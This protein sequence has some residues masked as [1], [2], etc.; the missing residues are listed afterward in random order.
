MADS[1][2]NIGK[3]SFKTNIYPKNPFINKFTGISSH[4]FI[5]M[6]FDNAQTQ[7]QLSF[8]YNY[9]GLMWNS[10]NVDKNNKPVANG[11]FDVIYNRKFTIN[12]CIN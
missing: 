9:L 11:R 4:S 6:E 7:T 3:H 5:D 12:G 1:D 2:E 8:D 10:F